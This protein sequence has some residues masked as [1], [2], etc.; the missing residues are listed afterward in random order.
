MHLFFEIPPFSETAGMSKS[1]SWSEGGLPALELSPSRRLSTIHSN[2]PWNAS[3]GGVPSNNASRQ[4][5]K[6]SLSD[7][8]GLKQ[9]QQQPLKQQQQSNSNN[10]ALIDFGEDLRRRRREQADLKLTRVSVLE[11]FDPLRMDD[12]DDELAAGN[13]KG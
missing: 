13:E 9:K 12:D 10:N 11:A 2:G 7:H 6:G 3:S 5:M 8:G 1:Q 4:Q